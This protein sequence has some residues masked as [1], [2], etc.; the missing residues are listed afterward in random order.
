MFVRLYYNE[1]T[2]AYVVQAYGDWKRDGWCK[3]SPVR[4]FKSQGDAILFAEWLRDNI[5]YAPAYVRTFRRDYVVTDMQ[6]RRNASFPF[7]WRLHCV[8]Y[9]KM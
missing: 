1:N 9:W 7:P 8:E 5:D 2:Q 6:M 3:W 4:A